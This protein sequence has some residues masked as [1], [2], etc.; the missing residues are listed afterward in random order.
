[1]SNSGE[2]RQWTAEKWRERIERYKRSGLTRRAFCAQE[3]VGESS[4]SAWQRRLRGTAATSTPEAT[5]A[6]A[7]FTEVAVSGAPD[8]HEPADT[9]A[10]CWDVELELG[11]G[12]C[13]RIRRS[14]GC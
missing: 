13:L 4:L 8:A 7:L 10:P 12:V 2:A 9:P 14:R 11:E 1:M 6:P 3:G 5:Q